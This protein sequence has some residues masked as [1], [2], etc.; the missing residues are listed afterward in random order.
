[1]AR[2]HLI[3]FIFFIAA[4][5][6]AAM[7]CRIVDILSHP[8]IVNNAEFWEKYATLANHTD[9]NI[10]A[11]IKKMAPGALSTSAPAIAASAFGENFEITHRAEKAIAKL[12][13]QNQKHLDEFIKV[14][15]EGGLQELRDRP[16]RWNFKKMQGNVGYSVRLDSGYRV[17]FLIEE[18]RIKILDV[19]NHIGH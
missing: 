11:L 14:I 2:N 10:E 7:S 4:F 19:G 17:Q 13:A 3:F 1:M 15:N 5:Q 16:G 8:S 9:Q 6:A 18:G 12:T